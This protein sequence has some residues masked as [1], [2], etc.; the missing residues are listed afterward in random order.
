MRSR[1][2]SATRVR[3]RRVHKK[4]NWAADRRNY[5]AWSQAE[6][7]L[8]RKDPG[9]GHR[10]VLTVAQL[11]KFIGLLPDWDEIAVGLDAIVLDAGR[12]DAMGWYDSGVVA[13]C[14]WPAH[15]GFWHESSKPWNEENEMLL[16]LLNVQI[17]QQDGRVGLLWT[18]A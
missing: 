7:R 1:R 18:E 14:A 12:D 16:S 15:S 2:Q 11:R 6:I 9:P 5:F 4:N 8:D 17:G 13:L 10:H 3:K